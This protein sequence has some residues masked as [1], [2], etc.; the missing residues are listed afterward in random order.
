MTKIS[1]FGVSIL[2]TR[3]SQAI[4]NLEKKPKKFSSAILSR[5]YEFFAIVSKKDESSFQELIASL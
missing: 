3:A 4:K 5:I 1:C 2:L